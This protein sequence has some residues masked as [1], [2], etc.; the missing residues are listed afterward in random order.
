[1]NLCF[2]LYNYGMTYVHYNLLHFIL[3]IINLG[4]ILHIV[5]AKKPMYVIIIR[6]AY[7][8]LCYNNVCVILFY[9]FFS[10]YIL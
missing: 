3:T 4:S 5:D 10:F 7:C 6:H 8:L 9:A 2:N 1:M